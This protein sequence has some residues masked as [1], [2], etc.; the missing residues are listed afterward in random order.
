[1][2]A[3]VQ[4]QRD[5]N[6]SEFAFFLWLII[7]AV[8]LMIVITFTS[9]GR[10]AAKDAEGIDWIAMIKIVSR[11][12]SLGLM[13]LIMLRMKPQQFFDLLRV[14]FWPFVLLVAWGIGSTAWSARM[15]LSLAQAGC[16]G[17]LVVLAITI[18]HVCRNMKDISSLMFHTSTALFMVSA[19]IVATQIFAPQW[20]VMGRNAAGDGAVGILHPTTAASTA[21]LGTLILLTARMGWTQWAWSRWLFF[22]GLFFH[23]VVLYWSAARLALALTVAAAG[24]LAL[25]FAPKKYLATG[26]LTIGAAATL[27]IVVSPDFRILESSGDEL[28]D[29]LRRGQTSSQLASFSGRE[30]LWPIMWES[31]WESPVIG[32]GFYVTTAKGEFKV[33]NDKG[34]L[35]AHNFLLQAMTTLGLVGSLLLVA[36][37]FSTVRTFLR[38]RFASADSKPLLVF[39]PV[40]WC[41]YLGW[42]MLNVSFMAPFQPESVVF[43]VSIGIAVAWS[44]ISRRSE[45]ESP[46]LA[47]YTG[48]FA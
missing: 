28:F 18:A 25:A 26:V 11:A 17:A 23:G 32:H 43:F 35:S 8:Y 39:L 44:M 47:I 5:S 21:S 46:N 7:A 9:P 19:T 24:V 16:F 22:P 34:N 30:E 20:G 4:P 27:L 13:L 12:A 29:Y 3:R 6:Q 36:A 45:H 37:I 40:L 15:S 38:S 42:G 48:D 2:I 31:F 1:M 10:H 14:S 41:W 33:W